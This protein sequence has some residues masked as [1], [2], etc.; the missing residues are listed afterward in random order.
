V[1]Q[2][3]SLGG[4][5]RLPKTTL[6]KVAVV[7]GIA[8]VGL[9]V[10]ILSSGPAIYLVRYQ[11]VSEKVANSV[12]SPLDSLTGWHPYTVYVQWWYYT[13]AERDQMEAA[14]FGK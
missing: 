11:I 1:S 2:L 6:K 13:K 14:R 3:F 8:S 12:Y 7:A 9:F 4:I 5:M 10:Y